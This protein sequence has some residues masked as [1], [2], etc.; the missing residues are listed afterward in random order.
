LHAV[1]SALQRITY[2][3]DP[4]QFVLQATTYQPFIS[5]F[6]QTEI[7]KDD[8]AIYGIRACFAPRSTAPN[9]KRTNRNYALADFASA[10]A[11]ELRRGKL[12]DN[13]DFLRFMFKNGTQ[14]DFVPVHVFEHNGD[15][16]LTEFIYRVEVC[17]FGS[18]LGTDNA[19]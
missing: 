17:L 7:T 13:R 9:P 10:L 11:I 8:S 4:T 5:L 16:P 1:I 15:I 19:F 3:G 12:P 6:N 2:D 14:N 18:L